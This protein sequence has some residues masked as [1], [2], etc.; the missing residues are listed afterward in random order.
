MSETR[1]SEFRVYELSECG[2]DGYPLAWHES[3]K[4]AVREGAGHR[5]VRCGH[6]YRKGEH[7]N[8]EWTPCD[9]RCT[10]EGPVRGVLPDGGFTPPWDVLATLNDPDLRGVEAQWRILTVHHLTGDKRDLRWWNL[11]ALCQ[12]CHLQ[13]QGRV[14][15]E[16]V[17]PHEHSEW[18]KPYAAG[19]YAATYLDEDLSREET[20]DRLDDLLALELA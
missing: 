14:K 6:P 1:R 17:Y 11:A 2:K 3:V 8:G 9:E 7:G 18:F 12:R 20:M 13:I 15:M 16:Q 5:C 10:H 19:Y 4:D